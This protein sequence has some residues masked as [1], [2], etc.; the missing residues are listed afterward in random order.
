MPAVYRAPEGT[1]LHLPRTAALPVLIF[2]ALHPPGAA[3]QDLSKALWPQLHPNTTADRIYTTMGTLKQVLNPAAGGPIVIRDGD[4]YRLNP[5]HIEVDLW[6]LHAAVHAAAAATAAATRADALRQI[7]DLYH[8][9]L[10]DGWTWSWLDPPREATRRYFMDA[11]AALAAEHGDL[12][13]QR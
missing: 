4:R 7:V 9:D 1:A 11:R 8:G 12:A 10:A 5:H 6:Q 3:T 13:D 2:L